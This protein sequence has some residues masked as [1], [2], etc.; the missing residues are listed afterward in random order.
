VKG[1]PAYLGFAVGLNGDTACV[2]VFVPVGAVKLVRQAFG[3]Q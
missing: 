1:D 2:D 3:D